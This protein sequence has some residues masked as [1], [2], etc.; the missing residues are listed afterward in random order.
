[1]GT[2]SQD[3]ESNTPRQAAVRDT[4]DEAR[5]V[6]LHHPEKIRNTLP[7]ATVISCTLQHTARAETNVH[8]SIAFIIKHDAPSPKVCVIVCLCFCVC[9]CVC[10]CV[11]VLCV[12]RVSVSVCGWV[13]ACVIVCVNV[14]VCVCVCVC[15]LVCVYVCVCV[16]VY[17]DD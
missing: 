16:C 15:V 3:A 10:V 1:M 4:G 17:L 12:L 14:C 11:F 9:V 13:L 8:D 5:E 7:H 6:L 2:L